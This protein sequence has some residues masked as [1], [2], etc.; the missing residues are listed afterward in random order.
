MS[1]AGCGLVRSSTN[2][3]SKSFLRSLEDNLTI[4]SPLIFV[5]P[6]CLNGRGLKV[7]IGTSFV[8]VVHHSEN[9]ISKA[10]FGSFRYQ[11]TFQVGARAIRKVSLFLIFILTA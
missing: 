11:T 1:L 6:S 5:T 2:Q 9:E 7:P 3:K 8:P 10:V 4:D